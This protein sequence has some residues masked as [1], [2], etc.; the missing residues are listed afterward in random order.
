MVPFIAERQAIRFKT[1]KV[2]ILPLKVRLFLILHEKL[3][4][5]NIIELLS[6]AFVASEALK[7]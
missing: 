5:L 1:P 7:T 2:L 4:L 3:H 6:N